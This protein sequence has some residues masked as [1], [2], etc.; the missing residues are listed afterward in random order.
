MKLLIESAKVRVFS[1]QMELVETLT[2]NVYE[3]V[4]EMT[5]TYMGRFIRV[6]KDTDG[7]FCYRPLVFK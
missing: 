6:Y 3:D 4:G 1:G 2:I 7:L 5:I